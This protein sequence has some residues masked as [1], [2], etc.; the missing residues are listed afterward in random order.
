M[1][2][3]GGPYF[4][5]LDYVSNRMDKVNGFLSPLDAGLLMA[6]DL[7]QKGA[8]I[9]GD[10]AEIGVLHGRSA[11]LLSCLA[12]DDERV[13][14]VDIFDL[15]YPNPPY[16]HPDAFI[17]NALSLGIG[18]ER[19]NLVKADTTKDASRVTESLGRKS[20]RLFHVDGDHRLMHILA[21]S[22]IAIDTTSPEGVIVFDDVF[23]Y[24][25]PEVTEGILKTFAG[26]TDFVPFA[27]SPNKAY[28]CPPEHKPR[29][30]AYVIE[31]LPNN[32]DTEVRRLL[33]HWVLTF[34]ALKPVVLRYFDKAGTV[35]DTML[36]RHILGRPVDFPL[37]P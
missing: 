30:A 32:L 31:C 8:E 15:Y 33:D 26:R 3:S 28:F 9:K 34:S 11:F 37:P 1:T 4:Q 18:L 27:L 23:S 17:G 6:I 21:D 19:F 7:A 10:L 5:A 12:R 25:M 36:H 29:Y 20:Q 16:N 35:D 13:Q 14:A 2:G 22:K 24:L